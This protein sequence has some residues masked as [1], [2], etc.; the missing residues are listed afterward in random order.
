MGN[1]E[2]SIWIDHL[3]GLGIIF[4]I[5]GHSISCPD[6]LINYFFSFH[7]PLFFFIAGINFNKT[8]LEDF[9]LFL[10]KR[11]MRLLIPYIF[12]N[13]LS[14]GFWIIRIKFF[15]IPQEVPILR[16]LLGILYGN[17]H[18]KWLIHNEP[19]WFFICL[20]T[21][22]LLLFFILKFCRTKKQIIFILFICAILGYLDA[23]YLKIRLPWGIDVALT[24]VVFSGI[25]YLLKGQLEAIKRLC[26]PLLLIFIFFLNLF[27]SF[28]NNKIDM[29]YNKY[30]NIFLFYCGAFSGIFFWTGVSK[31][32]KNVNVLKYIGNN[33]LSI[34]T[35]HIPVLII[36][37]KLM[38]MI[39]IPYGIQESNILFMFIHA[40]FSILMIVPINYLFNKYVPFL[41]GRERLMG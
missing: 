8:L 25:G 20:F 12:F 19:L 6:F 21:T 33:S 32:I 39:G 24:A 37:V 10:K 40:F 2:R 9:N 23:K 28:L 15:N 22:Q 11:I 5:F 4:I 41:V 13:L 38:I 16:P 1:F 26:H 31:M 34:F 14:Y 29:N 27:I 18:N 35:L 17:G 30:N 3:K 7:V 36:I